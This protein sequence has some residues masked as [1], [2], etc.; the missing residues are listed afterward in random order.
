MY[1]G[2]ENQLD[3]YEFQHGDLDFGVIFEDSLE[4]SVYRFTIQS[5]VRKNPDLQIFHSFSLVTD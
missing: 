5:V 1:F 3:Q 2:D 4:L